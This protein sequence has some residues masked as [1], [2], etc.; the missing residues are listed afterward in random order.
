MVVCVE[1]TKSQERFLY[2]RSPFRQEKKR[3]RIDFDIPESINLMSFAFPEDN[4]MGDGDS[5]VSE[6]D[7]EL[8]PLSKDKIINTNDYE[9][10]PNKQD[11][12]DSF[13]L[14]PNKQ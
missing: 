12:E 10:N 14:N 13:S 8:Q 1:P 11:A 9:H 3:M 4:K 5:S 2:A 7:M 6:D